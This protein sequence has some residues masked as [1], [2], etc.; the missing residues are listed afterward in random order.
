MTNERRIMEALQTFDL[1]NQLQIRDE[2]DIVT[3]LRNSLDEKEKL[4]GNSLAEFYAFALIENNPYGLQ[5]WNAYFGP[6]QFYNQSG[7]K[8]VQIEL[9][10]ITKEVVNYWET[11][12]DG[13]QNPILKAR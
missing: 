3:L 5:E 10:N 9:E 2:A 13:C 11:R 1:D 6:K 12:K 7:E 4:S 8:K